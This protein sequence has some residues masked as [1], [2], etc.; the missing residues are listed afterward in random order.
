MNYIIEKSSI[1]E[2]KPL[3][4][5]YLGTLTCVADDYWE[6]HVRS[7]E[8]YKI[9]AGD[10]CIGYF[11][12]FAAEL[13]LTQFYLKWQYLN[14][15]QTIFE[16]ILK[17]YDIRSA[18]VTTGDELFLSLCMDNFLRIEKQAYFFDGSEKIEVKPAEYPR[19]LLSRV[20]PEELEE[21]LMNTGSFFEP[22][23]KAQLETGEYQLYRMK[24]GNEILGYGIIV[25]NV[26]LTGYGPCG[27]I[28][29]EK[30]RRKGIGRSIQ[31][32]MADICR[33]NGLIPIAGCWYYNHLSKKTIESTGR[34]T[35]TRLLKVIFREED[36][37][38]RTSDK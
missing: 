2:I 34:F 5:E 3:M 12:V 19:S 27:M 15:A 11:A 16:R 36:D 29:L 32:H 28:T 23:S 25:P 24:E 38:E 8:F 13:L 21:V 26:L 1:V 35:K 20:E 22:I 37:K 10:N 6:Y 14:L 17:D 31:L 30:H 4:K 9:T 33:E 18:Y 7:A